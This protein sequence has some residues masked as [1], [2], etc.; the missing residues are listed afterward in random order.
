MIKA[1]FFD[2]DGVLTTNSNG[3]GTI[4]R[5]I[6]DALPDISFDTLYPC[7][8]AQ[9]PLLLSGK[10]KH[11]DIWDD[12]CGCVGTNID[13]AILYDALKKVP[14]NTA[15]FALAKEL[16]K[17]YKTGIITDNTKERFDAILREISLDRLFDVIILSA[18]TGGRKDEPQIFE[19]ALRMAGCSA[20]ECVF[21]DNQERNLV[22]PS[23]MGFKTMWHDDTKNNVDVLRQQLR[24]IG[25]ESEA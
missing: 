11:A 14:M 18:D 1:I 5:N 3:S 25:V 19:E 22:V 21:I 20:Q 23:R 13:I 7:Y 6:V 8:R 24:A 17:K 9:H 2:F 15:M 10:V 12:V 4:C 16:R